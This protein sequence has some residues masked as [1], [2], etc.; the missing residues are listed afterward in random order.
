ME[1]TLVLIKPDGI[2][3]RL[4][5]EIISFY[6]R[7]S[8]NIV[9]LKMTKANKDIV[10]EHYKEHKGREYYEELIAYITQD[11]LIAMI[12]EG[13]NVIAMIRKINGI[14]DP[15][16]ADMGS[17]RG[18]YGTSKQ[19]NLVHASDSVESSRREINIWF[20]EMEF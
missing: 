18:M 10:E 19:I 12:I 11:K 4:V 3:R 7:K 15:L 17:I 9:A 2:K 14:T 5:G 8:L 20:P 16:E 1:K 13:E 6:E